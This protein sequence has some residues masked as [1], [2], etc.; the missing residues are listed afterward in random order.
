MNV[1]VSIIIPIYKVEP[2]IERCIKSVLH[3]TYRNLEVILVDDCTPDRSME[4]A[5]QLIND[6]EKNN[7]F[8]FIYLKHDHNR[9]LSAARNTGIDAATGDYVFFLDSD[10]E[11][12]ENCIALLAQPLIKF[13]YNFVMGYY[14]A[15]GK[16]FPKQ[17]VRGELL[18]QKVIAKSY[19]NNQWHC[20]A[21]NKLCN[22]SY[23]KKHGLLFQ[24]GLIHEDE[25]WSA[26]LASTATSIY[27]VDICTYIYY[28]RENSITEEEGTDIKLHH[29]KR[30]LQGFYEFQEAKNISFEGVEDVENRIIE[31]LVSFMKR[32]GVPPYQRY[33]TLR[34]CDKR[35]IGTRKK[36]YCSFKSKILNLDKFMPHL[37]GYVYKKALSI[38]IHLKTT[39]QISF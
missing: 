9:G 18:N 5:K 29:Y 21:W 34:Q 33:L 16:T 14:E 10:D 3:Q 31:I 11:I 23:I 19:H 28:I 2:Y 15:K 6:D 26:L 30:V 24:E 4:L 39:I 8:R 36:V 25:L 13:P 37:I 7:D 38:I 12:T 27:C 20:M 22:L 1:K 17:D 32:E 35:S